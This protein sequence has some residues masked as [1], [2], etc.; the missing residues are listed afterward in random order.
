[1]YV[2]VRICFEQKESGIA[3]ALNAKCANAKGR[4]LANTGCEQ[5]AILV[6][7]QVGEAI[8]CASHTELAP[9]GVAVGIKFYEE[10]VRQS[11]AGVGHGAHGEGVA[12]GAGHVGVAGRIGDHGIN[13]LKGIV[14]G[15]FGPGPAVGLGVED[16]KSD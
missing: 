13:L 7:C 15:M 16:I 2:A 6:E 11:G 10:A 5:I 8:D 4:T 14:I 9:Q 1:M 3:G 12:V